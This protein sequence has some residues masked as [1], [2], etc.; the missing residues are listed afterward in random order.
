MS[1]NTIDTKLSQLTAELS[2]LKL[3]DSLLFLNHVLGVSR[4]FTTDSILEKLLADSPPP[5]PHV[6][7][8][9]AK[10]LL[11]H[12]SDLGA[13]SMDW[14]DFRRL[15]NQCIAL[16][17]PIQHDPNWKH[18]DPSGFFE[19]KLQQQVGPQQQILVRKY[20]LALGLFR[21]V[22]IVEWPQQYDLRS[23]IESAL[24][25]PI[26]HFMGMGH[27]SFALR[28]AKHQH[29]ECIGTFTLMKL[30]EAFSQGIDFC[31]PEVWMP[32]LARVACDRDTF[33]TIAFEAPYTVPNSVFEQF[34]FNPL[35]RNPITELSHS[36]YLATDPELII[37]RVTFG[38]FYDLFERDRTTFT[39]RFGFAFE[40][41]VG[42]L[43][44]SA[45][46]TKRLWSASDWEL[47]TGTQ[48]QRPSIGDW[49][50]VGDSCTVLLECKS[51]RPSIELATYGSESSTEEVTKRVFSAIKQL[52]QHSTGINRGEW[53]E[54]GL[55][56]AP[57]T[58][59]VVT[60]GKFFTVNGPFTRQRINRLLADAKLTPIP[61]VVLS[62]EELDSVVRLVES[63]HSFDSLVISLASDDSFNPL[64]KFKDELD[65]R[66]V[67][68]FAF[69]KG[70][71]FMDDI[72]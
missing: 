37:D 63:G 23:D 41:F 4:G 2:A 9:L 33:R 28:T 45:C 8:L 12:A 44:A 29:N 5:L 51:M 7:H 19:R 16:D 38:M 62:I 48:K 53:E 26:E 67:S 1:E 66:C 6:T 68:S 24:Q 35:R 46:Q 42:Q 34:G 10:L 21:D 71:A 40:Q 50:Y 32:Y 3:D 13:R 31:V 61:F 59:V 72:R 27:L 49:A 15:T 17:D 57:T 65:E 22:G 58:G 14:N 39:Q 30:A 60:Y 36:R 64:H 25:M 43:L 18:A 11:L 47:A 55:P 69:E 52:I 20:G 70:N 56:R 54:Y